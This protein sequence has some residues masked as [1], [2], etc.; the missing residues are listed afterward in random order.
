MYKSYNKSI[1][2]NQLTYNYNLISVQF[3]FVCFLTLL[4]GTDLTLGVGA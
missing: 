2:I 3:V 4:F 1:Y